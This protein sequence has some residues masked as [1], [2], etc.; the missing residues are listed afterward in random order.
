MHVHVNYS[1]LHPANAFSCTC[2]HLAWWLSWQPGVAAVMSETPP[3]TRMQALGQVMCTAT[4]HWLPTP[5]N[6]M[7]ASALILFF[8]LKSLLNKRGDASCVFFFF[9]FGW[10]HVW[11]GSCGILSVWLVWLKRITELSC[12]SPLENSCLSEEFRNLLG[13][14]CTSTASC[15]FVLEPVGTLVSSG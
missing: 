5:K 3:R 13:Y 4:G 14:F 9:F 12:L 11:Y 8:F 7:A 10:Q 6:K 2:T 15:A 1:A